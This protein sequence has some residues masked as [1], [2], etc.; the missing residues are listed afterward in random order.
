M[1]KPPGKTPRLKGAAKR[2]KGPYPLGEIP[3]GVVLEVGRQIVHRLAVGHADITGDD[4]GGIFA[5]A[6]EGEHRSR[7]L[8]IADVIRNGCA[9]SVKTVKAGNPFT[10]E[11]IRIISGRNSPDY[12]LDISNPRAD[13]EETGRAVLK[14]WNER[15]NEAM[16]S[17]DELRVV[18]FLRNMATREFVLFEQ[19]AERYIPNDYRWTTNIRRNLEG[20]DR[21][22]GDLV[23][24]WQ[25]H[26]SQFT[27]HRK[28]PA[29]ARKFSIT[30]N[31]PIIEVERVLRLAGYRDDW[32]ELRQ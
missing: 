21:T 22:T 8:G 28:V 9:W 19:E 10:Q 15:V 13:V 30:R 11:K 7:P 2:R 14:I 5:N 17:H 29:A 20:H 12:S 4:F 26:G 1:D 24:T 16:G 18:V 32:V 3:D 27:I 31:V 6:I 25:P 23:F